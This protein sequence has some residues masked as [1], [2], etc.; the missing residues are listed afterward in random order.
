MTATG[1]N[2]IDQSTDPLIDLKSTRI[3]SHTRTNRGKT[4]APA[5]KINEPESHTSYEG[6]QQLKHKLNA[7]GKSESLY[8]GVMPSSEDA[9]IYLDVD[10]DP[11]DKSDNPTKH[12]EVS[13]T[14]ISFIRNNPTYVEK[15]PGGHGLHIIYKLS[16]RDHETLKSL[17][18][19]KMSNVDLTM[20]MTGEM[21][22]TNAFLII[23]ET[24]TA[25]TDNKLLEPATLALGDLV[26]I[27]PK[28]KQRLLAKTSNVIGMKSRQRLANA[29]DINDT[30]D[31]L[32]LLPPKMNFYLER[33]YS[34]LETPM[35]PNDYDHWVNV[36]MCLAHAA[37]HFD[38]EVVQHEYY[39]LFDE[40]SQIDQ[41]KYIGPED[42]FDKWSDCLRSTAQKMSEDSNYQ[43]ALTK[44]TLH[45]LV[46]LC[47]PRY[48]VVDHKGAIIWESHINLQSVLDFNELRFLADVYSFD[49][50]YVECHREV[51]EKLFP[52]TFSRDNTA[53]PNKV[54]VFL[55]SIDLGLRTILEGSLYNI[56]SITKCLPV[57][58]TLA[59]QEI[60]FD[61]NT[62]T[63][64]KFQ[65]WIESTPWD[66]TPRVEDV[67]G[68]LH[69]DTATHKKILD[70]Y[71]RGLYKC[72]LWLVGVRYN[73]KPASAPTVPILVGKEGIYKSTWVKS[74]FHD[75]PFANQYV[76]QVGGLLK[77]RK[78]L[79]RA[80][81]STLI[82]LIDE[83]EQSMTNA[84]K[85]KDILT[86]ETLSLRAHYQNSYVN[87]MKRGLILGTT[88]NPFMSGSDDGNRRLFRITVQHCDTDA[89]WKINMQ[90]VYAE[91][92][93][94]YR[95]EVKRGNTMPWVFSKE[96]NAMNNLLMGE[97]SAQSEDAILLEDYF[98]GPATAFKFDPTK[99]LGKQGGIKQ[100]KKLE[101]ERVAVSVKT[102]YNLLV[103]H[104]QEQ[105][106]NAPVRMPKRNIVKRKLQAFAARYTDSEHKTVFI[107]SEACI[108]GKMRIKNQDLYIVPP[109]EVEGDNNE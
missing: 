69:F 79:S 25:Y 21:I 62:N 48:E 29:P 81:Q 76:K 17:E 64:D 94:D 86:E 71:R 87:V 59:L 6:A 78:E 92:L 16:S 95:A 58:K 32:L 31:R 84:D 83:I 15:S 103:S 44:A 106:Y 46:N 22:F 96:E 33:A 28:L 51:A 70:H 30:R 80:L 39:L 56:P 2:Q 8:I 101:D 55:K 54:V 108:N 67:I 43:P 41:D 35:Q 61:L 1:D 75:T 63:Y 90:Q 34:R 88:N 102:M 97:A 13:P 99:L 3:W 36:C 73:G 72:L 10:V 91:L 49:S 98:G 66:G 40:W 23:T 53:D 77:D 74:L 57:L 60:D 104:L 50:V 93:Y 65:T 82:A 24:P 38:D 109:F 27:Y 52:I 47:Y 100:N 4:K 26:E 105:N 11:N 12:K 37:L 19:T 85:A 20:P 5:L 14:L 18:I 45:R 107:G 68:T 42:T 89:L 9:Y 7:S